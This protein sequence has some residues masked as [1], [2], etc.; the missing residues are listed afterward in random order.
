[1][2]LFVFGACQFAGCKDEEQ[3]GETKGVSVSTEDATVAVGTEMDVYASVFPYSYGNETVNWT[4]S[5]PEVATVEEKESKNGISLATIKGISLGEAVITASSATDETKKATIKVTVSSHSFEELAMGE[6]YSS[7]DLITYIVPEGYPQ[8]GDP[9]FTVSI[10]GKYT[11]VYTDINAWEKLVS[12]SYFDFTPGKEVEVVIT[13]S[14]SFTDYEILPKSNNITST[15][16]G[17][18]I[19]FRLN[20]ANQTFSIIYDDNY[21][22]NTFHLFANAIDVEAPTESN[23]NLIYFGPGYHDLDE[24]YGGTLVTNNKDIYIAG[25]AV[26]N[27]TI[28]VNGNGN[29]VSGHGIFMKTTP[30]NLVLI[31]NYA[32]ETVLKDFITCSHRDGGWTIGTHEASGVTFQNVKVVS[33]RYAST[34]GFD[35]VNSNNIHLKDVFIRS[36]DDAIAIKGLID[37][38]PANCPPCENMTF[39]NLQ[40]WNDCNNAMGLGA[41]TRAKY[42][43]DIHFKNIDVIFSYDD[44]NHHTELDERSVMNIVCLHGTFFEDITWE[45]VRVNRCERL[46][47]IT[48]KDNF[49]FGSIQGDQSTDGGVNGITYKN[50]TVESN[51]G[52]S[53]ANEILLNGWAGTPQKVIQNVTFDNVVIEGQRVSNK[54]DKHIITNNTNTLELVKD[55]KF[56]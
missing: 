11:G 13:S 42:Y 40:I 30:N 38:I 54:S 28:V 10:N 44:L 21:K 4:S 52:S 23:A 24:N 50:V 20:D 37:N 51:S 5:D 19:H 49:W 55:L 9:L 31:A 47:C 29:N 35:I 16:E 2:L 12:F 22:G 17:N 1:M 15:K 18:S 56:K 34:D 41:E 26:V 53:I 33:T 43:K 7:D 39:E 32:R 3:L 25:G 14:K 8:E 46:A 27:G 45:D 6:D 48:F 36:C